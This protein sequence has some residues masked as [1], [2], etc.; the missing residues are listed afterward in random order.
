MYNFFIVF[1]QIYLSLLFFFFTSLFTSFPLHSNLFSLLPCIYFLHSE[2]L[3]QYTFLRNRY[4]YFDSF[5]RLLFIY[6]RDSISNFS[7]SSVKGRI[8]KTNGIF[9]PENYL[10]DQ[11]KYKQT[12]L[13]CSSHGELI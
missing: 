6:S 8:K 13:Y 5:T 12:L 1:V 4:S 10:I 3:K 7:F 11:Q 2:H 9:E